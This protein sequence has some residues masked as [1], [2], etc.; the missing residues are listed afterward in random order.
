MELSQSHGIAVFVF[1]ISIIL[2]LSVIACA[3]PL[4]SLCRIA[5]SPSGRRE[6][7]QE[8]EARKR[9]HGQNQR[10]KRQRDDAEQ[11]GQDNLTGGEAFLVAKLH[12]KHRSD[13]GSR[14]AFKQQN[15]L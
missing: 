12:G 14:A 1:L 4:S 3:M 11:G 13:G 5:T 15:D 6:S 9:S 2:A 10:A 8:W 7:F